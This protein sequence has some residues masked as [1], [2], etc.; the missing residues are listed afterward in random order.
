MTPREQGDFG[1]RSALN[2]LAEQGAHVYLPF[3]HSPDIDLVAEIE[4]RLI[5]VEVKTT[6]SQDKLGHWHAP[7]CTRGGNQSWSHLVKYFDPNRCDYLFVHVG[8]GRRWFIPT[9]A[10]ECRSAI[11]LGG[12]KYSEFEIEN[13]PALRRPDPGSTVLDSG[14]S[15]GECQSGQM[16]QAVNLPAMPTQVRIL[17]PPSA[18]AP[19]KPPRP[20][21]RSGTT[22]VYPKRR[23]TLPEEAS[24][25]AGIAVGDRLRV[26]AT[27]NGTL[28]VTRIDLPEQ[29]ELF[30]RP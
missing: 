9:S 16:E 22:K 12:S 26:N 10:L 7:I 11:T 4:G 15:L 29:P 25:A 18:D 30:S 19:V 28:S 23:V 17:S 20:S 2:W 24:S 3:G 1:E 21:G 27:G 14:S 13:G 5:G 6:G 8:D